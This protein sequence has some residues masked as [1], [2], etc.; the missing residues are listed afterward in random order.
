MGDSQ[1]RAAWIYS[2]AEKDTR[3]GTD[4]CFVRWMSLRKMILGGY[5]VSLEFVF[6]SLCFKRCRLLSSVWLFFKNF[7]DVEVIR[8]CVCDIG[9][10]NSSAGMAGLGQL[11]DKAQFKSSNSSHRGQHRHTHTHTVL[12]RYHHTSMDFTPHR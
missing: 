10:I 8:V 7:L 2:S 12:T 5:S 11:C 4:K 6:I 9:G 3:D 1:H